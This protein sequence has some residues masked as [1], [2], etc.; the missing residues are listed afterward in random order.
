M[1]GIVG[2]FNFDRQCPVDRTL[3]ERL[4]TALAH[5]GPDDEGTYVSGPVGLGSRRLSII[6]VADGHQPIANEDQTIWT[7]FNGAIYNY[8]DLR[9]ELTAA[10]HQFRTKTDTEVLV[11]LY[12]E[13]GDDFVGRLNG[14]FALALWDDT[15]QRLLVCRDRIG[16]KPLYYSTRNGRVVF[17]SEIKA[18][19]LDPALSRELAPE[20]LR[21]YLLLQYTPGAQTIFRDIRRLRPGRMLVI[22]AGGVAERTYWAPPAS[23]SRPMTE[24]QYA[25]A[26]WDLLGDSVRR[27]LLSD[28]PLGAF[29]SGGLD[30]STV[31]AL[32]GRASGQPVRTFAVGFR[33]DGGY[34]ESAHAQ[35]VARHLGTEHETLVVES[36]DVRRLLPRV[37]K[38]LDEPIADFAALPTLLLAEFARAHVKVVLTGEGADELFAGYRHYRFP[39]VFRR[40]GRTPRALRSAM[41]RLVAPAMPSPIAKALRA[42]AL[43]VPDGYLLVKAVFAPGDLGEV[44]SP[45]LVDRVASIPLAGE[46]REVFAHM[47]GLDAVNAYLLADLRTWLPEDLLMKVDKT[48]MHVGLEARVPFLDHRLVELVAT[49]PSSLKWRDGGKYL[50]RRVAG[51]VLPREVTQRPK[52]GFTLPLDQW[53]QG[54]LHE[55]VHAVLGDGRLARRGLLRPGA[56]AA[57]WERFRRGDR[58]TFMRVWTVFNFELWCRVFL[59]ADPDPL[60]PA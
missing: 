44:L 3:L 13:L 22:D 50:L 27:R 49:M 32:M 48:T 11:H 43:A 15:R 5:R 30:S 53:F 6:G 8:P 35:A 9:D 52:H 57:L 40:Y 24:R 28:V 1:C 56:I 4:K 51:Q 33:V 60:A 34:D 7:V 37:V 29:L 46:L 19:L 55:T 45:D 41:A 47:R 36:M 21:D 42:G 59:D 31:V 23:E 38:A 12:E 54:P 58:A 26:V 25:D 2:I 14:M 10:G 39:A 20:A 16:E 18:L 17:A